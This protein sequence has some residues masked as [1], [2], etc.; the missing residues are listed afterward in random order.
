MFWLYFL[1]DFCCEEKPRI[2]TFIDE[3]MEFIRCN[4]EKLKEKSKLKSY[5]LFVESL[6]SGSSAYDMD[7]SFEVL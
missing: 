7:C 2:E 5:R 6:G 3:K 4:E 1:L